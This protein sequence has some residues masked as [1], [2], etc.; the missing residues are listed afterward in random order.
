MPSAPT[1]LLPF[2]LAS[3]MS[4]TFVTDGP[5]LTR[6]EPA[7]R[8]L[9]GPLFCAVGLGRHVMTRICVQYQQNSPT[10]LK[11]PCTPP[12]PPLT[13]TAVYFPWF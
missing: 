9:Y 10:A 13:T 12:P 8:L 3:Y 4:V 11:P 6:Y 1:L 2:L 5:V 7:A